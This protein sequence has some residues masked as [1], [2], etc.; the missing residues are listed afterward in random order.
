[1]ADIAQMQLVAHSHFVDAK[2]EGDKI[3]R[4]HIGHWTRWRAVAGASE[5][6]PNTCDTSS[7]DSASLR[8]ARG[9]AIR[10]KLS[11]S[12]VR[13]LRGAVATARRGNR[14]TLFLFHFLTKARN[15]SQQCLCGTSNC[16]FRS[17]GL[18]LTVFTSR[19]MATARSLQACHRLLVDTGVET[20][21]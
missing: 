17:C 9:H 6:L 18:T 20:K 10:H 3:S 4:T 11:N 2:H 21:Q 7:R 5:F 16:L 1:M 19:T 13:G 14:K 12:P 8:P 15:D